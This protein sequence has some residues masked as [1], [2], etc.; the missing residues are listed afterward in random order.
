MEC[1]GLN[2]DP[3]IRAPPLLWRV[4]YE[5]LLGVCSTTMLR[6]F[7]FTTCLVSLMFYSFS[8]QN[9]TLTV[10][11]NVW[12]LQRDNVAIYHEH[13]EKNCARISEPAL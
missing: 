12:V 13:S 3:R 2:F 9:L 4:T 8:L 5:V 6:S 1:Y 7:G 11:E 10:Y